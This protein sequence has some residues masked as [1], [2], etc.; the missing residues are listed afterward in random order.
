MKSCHSL[1]KFLLNPIL[2]KLL[3]FCKILVNIFLILI[4]IIHLVNSY[5]VVSL[6]KSYLIIKK[7]N[8][9]Y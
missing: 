8:Y 5:Y 9:K 3:K 6:I 7:N 4:N 2:V 1:K